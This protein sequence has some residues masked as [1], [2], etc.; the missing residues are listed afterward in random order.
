MPR[1]NRLLFKSGSKG[2]A[3]F[4]LIEVLIAITI[5]AIGL[6][7]IAGM[8]MTAIQTNSTASEITARAALAEGIMEEILSWD[9][10]DPRFA[11]AENLD[12]PWPFGT[13]VANVDITEHS[14]VGAGRF[15]AVYRVIPNNPVQGA[16]LV[17]VTME[18][19]VGRQSGREIVIT[20][21]KR[22]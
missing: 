12:V 3:G 14:V 6:L 4:T 9:S 10:T 19:E 8:Q 22:R 1:L 21:V 17:E 16:S 11:A 13:D 5:F 15:S 2:Q 7:A 20:A 18:S